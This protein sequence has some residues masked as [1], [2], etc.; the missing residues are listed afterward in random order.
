MTKEQFAKA[1]RLQRH[2]Q[3]KKCDL[4]D[5]KYYEDNYSDY[6]IQL[7]F[8]RTLNDSV[9]TSVEIYDEALKKEIINLVKIHFIADVQKSEKELEQL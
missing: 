8:K 1:E 4:K 2:I 9:F 5:I 3:Y 7:Q 6:P